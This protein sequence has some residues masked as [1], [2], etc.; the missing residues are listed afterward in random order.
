MIKERERN[1][2]RLNCGEHGVT[3]ICFVQLLTREKLVNLHSHS[4]C[5]KRDRIIA[6]RFHMAAYNGQQEVD[7]GLLVNLGQQKFAVI[8][9]ERIEGELHAR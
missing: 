6:T 1:V 5:H 2:K 3:R 8:L 4:L 7:C 9:S